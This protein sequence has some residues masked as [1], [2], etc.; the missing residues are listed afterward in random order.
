MSDPR[1]NSCHLDF[2]RRQE[3]R[4]AREALLGARGWL[5]MTGEQF[6]ALLA[7]AD[8]WLIRPDQ[9]LPAAN[10]LLIDPAADCTY[11]LK[12]GLNTIGRLPDNN[13]S[14]DDRFISRRHCVLL[15]HAWGG[16]DLHDTASR[17][18]TFVNGVRVTRPVHLT[19][20]DSIHV[21]D[22]RLL[23]VTDKDCQPGDYDAHPDTVV[24]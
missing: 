16:C 23:F 14:L 17:N 18:G 8:E 11:A 1:L 22:R 9:V 13:I 20:G 15:V 12:T 2:P 21:C 24:R 6:R 19:S 7:E 10:Y 3:Y 5:T 4:R